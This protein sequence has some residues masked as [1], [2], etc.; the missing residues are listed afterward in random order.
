MASTKTSS[1]LPS[2]PH[3]PDWVLGPA[4]SN[5]LN[6]AVQTGIARTGP[7]EM[8][9][10]PTDSRESPNPWDSAQKSTID[11]PKAYEG[12]NLFLGQAVERMQYLQDEFY[13]RVIAPV[14]WTDKLTMVSSTVQFLP[15][16]AGFVPHEGVPRLLRTSERKRKTTISRRGLAIYMEMGFLLT[17]EGQMYFV[18]HLRQMATGVNETINFEVLRR[19]MTT[20]EDAKSFLADGVERGLTHYGILNDQ[21]ITQLMADGVNSWY[22]MVLPG[23]LEERIPKITEKIRS[24][25]GTAPDA[26]IMPFEAQQYFQQMS[27]D[28][29]TREHAGALGPARVAAGPGALTTIM[30]LNVYITRSFDVEEHQLNLQR[31]TGMI[32]E[33][34]RHNG[35][36]GRNYDP[37]SDTFQI[38]DGDNDTWYTVHP[39]TVL[40][41]CNLYDANG[42]FRDI[43]SYND[44][45]GFYNVDYLDH[46]T[47]QDAANCSFYYRT[48]GSPFS[49]YGDLDD[50]APSTGQTLFSGLA[51]VRFIGQ[52]EPKH[53][54]HDDFAN[55]LEAIRSGMNAHFRED[56]EESLTALDAIVKQM[57][58]IPFDP[59]WLTVVAPTTTSSSGKSGFWIEGLGSKSVDNPRV[60]AKLFGIE[61]YE[62]DRTI[63]FHPLNNTKGGVPVPSLPAGYQ[64]FNG[65]KA[66]ERFYNKNS[67]SMGSWSG[68]VEPF[69]VIKTHLPVFERFVQYIIS[70]FGSDHPLV[71]KHHDRLSVHYP[72]PA[73]ALW[74][75]LFNSNSFT[76][77]RWEEAKAGA[78]LEDVVRNL[79]KQITDNFA[80][81]N[82]DLDVPTVGTKKLHSEHLAIDASLSLA[83][84]KANIAT[85]LKK[86]VMRVVLRFVL[87]KDPRYPVQ[88]LNMATPDVI[89]RLQ[90]AF[91]MKN[92]TEFETRATNLPLADRAVALA[93]T[94]LTDE[95]LFGPTHGTIADP[96]K[97][98]VHSVAEEWEKLVTSDTTSTA[99]STPSEFVRTAFVVSPAMAASIVEQTIDSS[100]AFKSVGVW[101]SD[102]E[103]PELPADMTGTTSKQQYLEK[104]FGMSL[105]GLDSE[106]LNTLPFLAQYYTR[107]D[108]CEDAH[109]VN[110]VRSNAPTLLSLANSRCFG[111]RFAYFWTGVS[112]LDRA[113]ALA[114]MLVPNRLPSL[115]QLVMR[116]IPLPWRWIVWRP[117]MSFDTHGLTIMSTGEGTMITWRR[118]GVFMIGYNSLQQ[119][120]HMTYTAYFGVDLVRPENVY[121]LFHVLPAGRNGG[122][123]VRPYNLATYDPVHNLWGASDD[124]LGSVFYTLTSYSQTR[125]FRS[126]MSMS[127]RFTMNDYRVD[128]A[129][130]PENL[131]GAHYDTAVLYVPRYGVGLRHYSVYTDDPYRGPES[132]NMPPNV[133]CYEGAQRDFNEAMKN[134]SNVSRGNGHMAK[135]GSFVGCKALREGAVSR[136]MITSLMSN[137][138]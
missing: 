31:W 63:G 28:R 135:I 103:M 56:V 47:A 62:Q 27:P 17:P 138:A 65:M 64:S 33:F 99:P 108:K 133:I 115:R 96:V 89:K 77:F 104:L 66:I 122:D 94:L 32:G 85:V 26:I 16:W 30:D 79:V 72:S 44:N 112:T 58:A 110:F 93:N 53:L 14:R 70:T 67:G 51:P 131:G 83:A 74:T 36:H 128:D 20:D 136:A 4:G 129:K 9:F 109:V 18:E 45:D 132:T 43:A 50:P 38:Y 25:R 105:G 124:G 49:A 8:L 134:Y 114:Y 39:M 107:L 91:T 130:I 41:N 73:S 71:N 40:D 42:D 116:K 119:M 54:N 117:H 1:L 101:F 113:L 5:P 13:T 48:G 118:E 10:G 34:N 57:D 76:A 37:R 11:L 123:G 121:N 21:S 46:F 100:G 75:T 55:I 88:A 125:N 52:I 2:D 68:S 7:W 78:S 81:P 90:T 61:D 3:R 111:E 80:V 126:P 84:Y 137:A 12:R 15:A 60:G 29:A 19:L 97:G 82:N 92:Y 6:P 59:E 102:P 23:F 127:G 69:K 87:E 106:S 95:R 22:G 86:M 120:I 98:T 35:Y 24:R